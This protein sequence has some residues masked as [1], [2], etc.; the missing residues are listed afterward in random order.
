VAQVRSQAEQ[1][2]GLEEKGLDEVEKQLQAEIK[3]LTAGLAPGIKLP[4]LG[5]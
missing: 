3:R 2:L 1:R 4:K 5:I